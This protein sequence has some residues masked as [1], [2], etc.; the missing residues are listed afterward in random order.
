MFVMMTVYMRIEEA[1]SWELLLAVFTGLVSNDGTPPLMLPQGW[2]TYSHQ[3]LMPYY[4]S[5]TLTIHYKQ[6]EK[7]DHLTVVTQVMGPWRSI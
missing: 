1:L 7:L 2:K 3:L 4:L 6:T 5:L